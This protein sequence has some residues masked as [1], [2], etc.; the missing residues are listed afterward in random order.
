MFGTKMNENQ[1][2]N[3]RKIMFSLNMQEKS[4]FLIPKHGQISA[5]T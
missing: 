1:N 3:T 2:E 4:I 5:K